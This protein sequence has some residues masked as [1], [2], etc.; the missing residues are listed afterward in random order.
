[1]GRVLAV[2]VDA[3]GAG[4]AVDDVSD[5]AR[6]ANIGQWM[7]PPPSGAQPT[8]SECLPT[9]PFIGVE[10][11]DDGEGAVVALTDGRVYD[12]DLSEPSRPMNAEPA[13]APDDARGRAGTQAAIAPLFNRTIAIVAEEGLDAGCA[14][15]PAAQGLRVLSVE[16]GKAPE[17]ESPVRFPGAVAPGRLIAS[18][19]LA[20]VAW[21][22]NG[23]RVVDFGQVRART[24]AQFVPVQADVVGVGLLPE[25]VV[26]TDRA[27]GLY[28]LERPDEGG[29]RASFWSQF[30][31]FLPYLGLPIMASAMALVPRLVA[32][33]A[34][35]RSGVGMPSPAP[36]HRRPA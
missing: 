30:L 28:V 29:G 1:M 18:G 7:V 14:D 20:Y 25:H 16:R 3:T 13:P 34:A 12:L 26:I 11:H 10:L 17:P 8:A 33:T 19:E 27:S 22:Q 23:L 5:P 31:S 24:V 9:S 6:P 36:A 32:A 21:R 4:V 15:P 35:A 2:R